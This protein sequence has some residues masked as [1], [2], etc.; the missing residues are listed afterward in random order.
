MIERLSDEMIKKANDRHQNSMEGGYEYDYILG[1]ED[2]RDFYDAQIDAQAKTME[3]LFEIWATSC[4]H[5]KADVYMTERDF[6]DIEASMF[7]TCVGFFLA[8][9]GVIKE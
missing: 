8:A 7:A 5:E 6:P 9:G 3:E 1:Q 2:A 4:K